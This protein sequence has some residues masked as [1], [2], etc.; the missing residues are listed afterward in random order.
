MGS[1]GNVFSNLMPTD[2]GTES[3]REEREQKHGIKYVTKNTKYE[4]KC[5]VSHFHQ[6]SFCNSI[7]ADFFKQSHNNKYR[8]K[9]INICL[10]F[11]Y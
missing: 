3:Q 11:A 9:C 8:C 4:Q 1:D 6:S 10:T 7:L 2:T 5:E